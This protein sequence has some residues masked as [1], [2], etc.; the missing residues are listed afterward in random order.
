MIMNQ[1]VRIFIIITFLALNVLG[2]DRHQNY[3]LHLF[4]AILE[5]G[6]LVLFAYYI[7]NLDSSI[8]KVRLLIIGFLGVIF[9]YISPVMGKIIDDYY[10][11]FSK[12]YGAYLFIAA[13]FIYALIIYYG[14]EKTKKSRVV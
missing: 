11:V 8:S 10:P 9:K 2:Y 6:G 13:L 12:N 14:I 5:C 7:I 3:T 4:Q 1:F